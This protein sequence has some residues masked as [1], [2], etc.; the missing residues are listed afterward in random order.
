MG[1]QQNQQKSSKPVCAVI[2]AAGPS[3]SG[4]SLTSDGESSDAMTPIAGKPAI[5]WTISY[6]IEN[7]IRSVSIVVSRRGNS[8]ERFVSTIFKD[9]IELTFSAPTTSNGVGDSVLKGVEAFGAETPLIVVLGDTV[10]YRREPLTFGKDSFVTVSE[11]QDHDRWC[12]AEMDEEYI[13]GLHDKPSIQVSGRMALTGIYYFSAGLKDSSDTICIKRE[14]GT[15]IEMSDL[16]QPLVKARL[17]RWSVDKNWLDVGNPDHVH[18]AHSTLV[19]SRSF[20]RLSVDQKR[21]TIKKTSTYVSKFYDEI[22]YFLL[23]PKNL[24]VYFPRI[25]DI[26]LS[27][28]NLSI[29]MEYYAYP[30]LADLFLFQ[31]INS[32]TWERIFSRLFSISE[33]F[34]SLDYGP[35]AECGNDIYVR[36]NFERLNQF[37]KELPL[38]LEFLAKDSDIYI[39]GERVFPLREAFERSESVLKRIAESTRLSPIHGDLCFSNILCEPARCLV[40]FIDPRGSFGKNGILGDFRYDVAKLHHSVIGLYDYIV[41]DLVEASFCDGNYTINIPIDEQTAK[42][43]KAFES[44]YYTKFE[45]DEIQVISAWLFLSMLPL[46]SDSVKR[47]KALALRGLQL[48]NKALQ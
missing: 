39:D 15:R 42:I 46:H 48:L 37:Q 17:L 21:G 29:E 3:H 19:Q 23:I 2:P 4:W 33:D 28:G 5:F 14:S 10:L 16:L 26:S 27:P 43:Q 7:G 34:F 9:L 18:L 8:V 47:Q 25:L 24:S 38:G 32:A 13:T 11:V 45:R 41:S 1:L 44:Q 40:K 6:L 20:N 22:N 30:T 36:K 31:K 12:M 35:G